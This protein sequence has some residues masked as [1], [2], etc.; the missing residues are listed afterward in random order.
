MTISVYDLAHS[1]GVPAAVTE[2]MLLMQ[3]RIAALE[4]EVQD[5][6]DELAYHGV[7]PK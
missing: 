6:M 4:A 2:T 3:D 7:Y 5:L 1:K